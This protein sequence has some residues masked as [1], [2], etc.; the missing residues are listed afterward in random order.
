[1]EYKCSL[2]QKIFTVKKGL[3][4]HINH[5]VCQKEHK[6]C[7]LCGHVFKNIQMYKYHMDHNV[8]KKKTPEPKIK[9][10]LKKSDNRNNID[11]STYTKDELILKIAQLEGKV[12][13]M[14]EHPQ[15]INNAHQ[16]NFIFPKAF[17]TEQIDH[18]SQRLP[19][20]LHDALT[21]HC[22]RSVEYLTEQIHCNKEIFPEYTN[23]YIRG[24]KSPFALVSDGEKFQNKPQKRIIEQIIEQSISMLQDYVD[25]HGEK[26]GQK[27]I[28]RYERYRNLVE[29]GEH[30]KKS[31]LRKEIEIEIAGMLLDMRPLIESIPQVKKMLDQLEEGQFINSV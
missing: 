9:I 10:K 22:N 4:Y 1:M 19:N 26:Y 29:S 27:I 31:E 14:N 11:Y 17:G 30:E 8:C 25:N 12:E 16:I 15:T 21:K 18:I 7:L 5:N 23:V 20:L 13:A 28:D 2:C 6:K 3:D 24:Y